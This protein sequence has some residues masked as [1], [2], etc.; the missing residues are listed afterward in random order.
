MITLGRPIKQIAV[1]LPDVGSYTAVLVSE[2]GW[3][4]DARVQLRFGDWEMVWTATRSGNQMRWD[5]AAAQVA[6]VRGLSRQTVWLTYQAG[7]AEPLQWG[8]GRVYRASRAQGLTGMVLGDG[9]PDMVTSPPGTTAAVHV[10]PVA[11]P[12]GT[13]GP[14][15]DAGP[16]GEQ[17]PPGETVASRGSSAGPA[18]YTHTQAKPADTWVVEHGLGRTPVAWSL[19]DNSGGERN[20]Y[21]VEHLGSMRLRVLMDVPTAG[22]FTT[23]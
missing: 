15:G 5:I 6:A 13:A 22:T 2:S 23:Y 4:A 17:G 16:R 11:G 20:Q 12:A 14:R 21:R 1:V 19:F 18:S 10:M 7:D 3:P 8:T 9:R